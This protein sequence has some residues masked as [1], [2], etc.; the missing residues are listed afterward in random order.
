[1]TK[2][3]FTLFLYFLCAMLAMA[4][5]NAVPHD[6]MQQI[7]SEIRTDNKYGLVIAP[8]DNNHKMD[9]PT[10]FRHDGRWYMSY[11]IYNG[12]GGK[13]GRGYETWLAVSDNL[14]EW[15]T[16]G[17]ILPFAD[18]GS[19]R[20]DENQRAG[21][22]A[23]IDNTWGGS[24]EPKK[25]NG[26]YWM[27]YFGGKGQG[28]ESGQLHEGMAFTTGDI[29]TAHVWQTLD[30]H[31]L[32][33]TDKDAGWW[34]S[35]TQYKSSI[36]YD[37][38]KKL[39]KPFVLFYNAGGINPANNVKAERIGIALSADMK[40]WTRYAGNPVVNHEEGISGDAYIQRIG[41]LY[42]MF[43]FGAFRK[44]RAYQAFNTFACS[45]NLIDWTDWTGDDLIYPSEKYDERF[46]HKSC[47]IKWNGTVYHFYCAVNNDDQR[48]IA[49]STSRN[50]GKS[51]LRFPK[52]DK[53]T[54]RKEISLNNDWATKYLA[55]TNIPIN[56]E[57]EY[58]KY[59]SDTIIT[60][61]LSDGAWQV[62]NIPHNHDNYYGARRL[63]HGNLHGTALYR[64]SFTIENQ[65][66][67]KRY[68]LF[69]EGV[70]SIA[71]VYVNGHL[72]GE[73]AGG[74]TTFT[75]D[76]TDYLNFSTPNLLF[77][78]A[79]H[80]A[81]LT[82]LPW[83]C[84]GCSSEWGFSEGSQP[85]GIFRP[86]TLVVSNEVR[87]EPFGVYAFNN[88]PEIQENDTSFLLNISTEIKNYGNREAVYEI[89]QK[90]TD[91]NGKQIAR[92]A[93]T[94]TLKPNELKTIYQKSKAIV[95]PHLWDLTNP[96][97]YKLIT[98]IRENG[99]LIDQETTPYGFRWIQFPKNNPSGD[100]RFFLNGKAVFING[101]CE[102]EHIL[103]GSHA[104]A[105][106]QI[107]A[108]MRQMHAAGFNA[109][110]EGHQ[111]HNLRYLEWADRNGM[112]FW[113]QFSAHI[114]YDT[115]EFRQNFTTLMRDWIRERR[116]SPSLILWGLQN[117]SVLPSDFAAECTQIIRETDKSSP[118]QRLVTTCN[119]GTGT[120][121]N[122]VQ[123]WSGTYGGNIE[124][125][126]NE[127]RRPDQ[128]L[129][130][131]YGAWRSVGLHS[132]NEFD[133]NSKNYSE[134]RFC[135]I[136]ERKITL[137]EQVK[138]S[139]VGQFQWLYASHDN[140]G[141]VQNDEG[142]RPIDK[143][144]PFNYKGLVTIW[145]EPTDAY[146]LY[147]AAYADKLREPMVYIVSHTWADRF[148]E[149][150]IKNNITVYSNC[151]EVRMQFLSKSARFRDI[152]FISGEKVG[153]GKFV[154]NNVDIQSNTITV[155]AYVNGELRAEDV[156]HL[157]NFDSS[158]NNNIEAKNIQNKKT[159]KLNYIYRVNCGGDNYTDNYGNRWLADVPKQ[160]GNYWGST[161]WA[162]EWKY[163]AWNT[164]SQSQTTDPI[165]GTDDDEL[166][167]SFRYGR[168]K[169]KYQFP[170][171]DGEYQVELYFVETWWGRANIDAEGFRIFDVA[172]SGDT[173]LKKLDVFKEVGFNKLLKKTVSGK[174][175]N[176][177]LEI[178]FPR[179]LAGQATISAIAIATEKKNIKAAA[180]SPNDIKIIPSPEDIDVF[181]AV[182]YKN[183][184][185]NVAKNTFSW[186]ITPGVA[187]IYALRF[188]YQNTGK[189]TIKA[190]ITIIDSKGE[191]M[192]N[193]IMQF[194]PTPGKWK[195]I[196]T[197]T[198]S[199]INAGKYKIIISTQTIDN[200]KFD[201]LEVQ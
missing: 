164:A 28:Y 150:G 143:I 149:K 102:Y 59:F 182:S 114:W 30:N 137:A 97:L 46:A 140:P 52:P 67:G 181:Q 76:I 101:T 68:F 81:M 94:I 90:L 120:D 125:Y 130:G 4:Q 163:L 1:M 187:N 191:T 23:L 49:V 66:V 95:N 70:G 33:P 16:L 146:Y 145:D 135:H 3:I 195:I 156:L 160:A 121:W 86:V 155:A 169:L 176:G 89:V 57:S 159:G 139:V 9:C 27:S 93:D 158:D 129:N 17:R 196:N 157:K 188:K 179:T 21:Y 104:F 37:K 177:L 183:D 84:G 153:N 39:G 106:E 151:D 98:M 83:V 198:G 172:I 38:D 10:V 131:E 35:I 166:F 141:R 154:F 142:S 109:F 71:E 14:L 174:S 53:E 5:N 175:K 60:S 122:V 45:Y 40:N 18:E 91:S 108:R 184:S 147:R 34:E 36:F 127:L 103:G 26:K 107:E 161:S 63:K 200:L 85:L 32:S 126:A 138:D 13:D 144:G 168:D 119:G 50:F 64:K 47:V 185:V 96:Y 62:V 167:R 25:F 180:S 162:D 190:E 194:P 56:R 82:T 148:T 8:T 88:I 123:N 199:Q 48:G 105:D 22:I 152:Y 51:L 134:E 2:H 65:G 115:P 75:L 73:H 201:G 74:R 186:T 132:E 171:P 124:N 7:Y 42:V 111:P 170:L 128:L 136:L 11:L 99:K 87:I 80:P 100:Q 55:S 92:I 19:G 189:E 43:Y 72:L 165:D 31:T 110:R 197:T 12:K 116:N 178:S 6:K 78:L 24:Y 69:F 192:R 113:S 15:S 193:D 133:A 79:H 41:D 117:E 173:V 112:L 77:V 61:S 20:W 58:K 29:T 44:D 54:F 118:S